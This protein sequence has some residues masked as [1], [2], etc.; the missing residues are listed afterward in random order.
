MYSYLLIL[1][2]I[3]SISI[4]ITFL[5]DITF[6]K[7]PENGLIPSI[8][9]IISTMLIVITMIKLIDNNIL[10]ISIIVILM[11]LSIVNTYLLTRIAEHYSEMNDASSIFGMA[12]FISCLTTSL[13]IVVNVIK[14]F[15]LI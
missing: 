9:S 2:S 6:N 11:I 7:N 4:L 1:C 3:I 8:S 10:Y 13:L 15:K 14:L 5:L 12:E